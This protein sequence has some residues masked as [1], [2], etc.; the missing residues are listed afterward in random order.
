M[1]DTTRTEI[2]RIKGNR[3]SGV[4]HGRLHKELADVM[5]EKC[6]VNR[7]ERSL[8]ECRQAV[9][10][11]RERF[12]EC[13]IDDH[14]AVF[15]TDL[16]ETIELGYMIDYSLTQVEG[17]LVRTESRGA[18]LRLDGPDGGKLPRDDER[19]MKHTY[20]WLAEDGSVRLDW[21]TVHLIQ[22]DPD[23]TW[24]PEVVE[25]MRPRERKY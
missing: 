14:G 9:L 21:G 23:G 11:L 12:R 2:E 10:E 20:A 19:F 13:G 7:T 8:Q 16:L 1:D 4:K 15:N 18:H 5:M 22:D 6:S 17:A 25:H 24:E 3:D